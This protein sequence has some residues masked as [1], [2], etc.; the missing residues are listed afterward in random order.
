MRVGVDGACVDGSAIDQNYELEC[1]G[2]LDEDGGGFEVLVVV[3]DIR[4]EYDLKKCFA[5]PLNLSNLPSFLNKALSILKL[6]DTDLLS[7]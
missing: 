6:I 1:G 4:S 2:V 7:L 5:I 3:D